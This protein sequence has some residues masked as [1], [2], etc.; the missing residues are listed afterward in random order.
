MQY[1][2]V[3]GYTGWAQ[4]GILLAFL[5]LGVVLTGFVQLYFVSKAMGPGFVPSASNTDAMMAALLKP[6]NAVY[7]QLSQILGT[8]LLLFLPSIVFILICYKNL[9]WAGFSK[10]FNFSQIAIAFLIIL[11]ANLFA[12]PFEE[13]TKRV[14]AHFPHWDS[15]AK[16]AEQLYNDEVTAM[17]TLNTWPQFFVAVF[18]I[19]FL[20]ALFEEFFFRGV[21]QN[22][23]VRWLKKPIVAII[24]TSVIFSFIH[25]SYYLFISRFILGFALGLL[26]YQS[27]NIWVN[28]FAHF[29]NNFIG[30]VQLFNINTNTKTGKPDISNMD[31]KMPI[32]SLL[33]TFAILAGL[34]M[35][36]KKISKENREQ[37]EKEENELIAAA[38][39]PNSFV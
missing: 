9:L 24:I 32:W 19:A 35:Q 3:K 38:N 39:L 29:L 5:G 31:P 15:L 30:V 4:L 12:L 27:K 36:F 28:T 21:L 7:A 33:L 23:L 18:I 8:F 20:P 16:Q 25:A 37:I 22:L 34:F 14:L 11:F 13:I 2:N 6:E 17:S 26:F 10:Y 1:R